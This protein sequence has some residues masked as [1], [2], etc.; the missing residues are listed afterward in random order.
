[1][2]LFLIAQICGL[3]AVLIEIVR[4]QWKSPRAILVADI[5][6]D[7]FQIAQFAAQTNLIKSD[8]GPG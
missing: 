5:G 6:V 2:S 4:A 8:Q 3:V 1:M 7:R